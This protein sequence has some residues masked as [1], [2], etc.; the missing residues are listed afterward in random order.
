MSDWDGLKKN[1]PF[2]TVF[3]SNTVKGIADGINEALASHDKL[4]QDAQ[5]LRSKKIEI[6]E[7]R[8]GHIMKLIVEAKCSN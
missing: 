5:T 4:S 1:F 7:Q 6:W 8:K 2:G 3:V